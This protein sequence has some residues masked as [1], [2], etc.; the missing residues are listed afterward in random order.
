[1]LQGG[2]KWERVA[3]FYKQLYGVDSLEDSAARVSRTIVTASQQGL[4]LVLMSHNGPTGLGDQSH[5]ICGI[6]W[7]KNAGGAAECKVSI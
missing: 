6:D 3:F 5:S 1:M 4:P 2:G 7:T